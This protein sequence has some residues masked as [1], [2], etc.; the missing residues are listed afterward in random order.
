MTT[1]EFDCVEMK[2]QAQQKLWQE[3]ESRQK[4]FGSFHEFLAAAIQEDDW[5]REIWKRFESDE[6]PWVARTAG[7]EE[8]RVSS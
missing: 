5:A 7:V 8:G 1:K 4:E 6:A 2:H 3:Y